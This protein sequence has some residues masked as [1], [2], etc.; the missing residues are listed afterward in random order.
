M[1]AYTLGLFSKVVFSLSLI[2]YVLYGLTY[3]IAALTLII[4]RNWLVIIVMAITIYL[5]FA[6]IYYLN[7]SLR[8]TGNLMLSSLVFA[9]IKTN[10]SLLYIGL[11]GLFIFQVIDFIFIVF[12]RDISVKN[13]AY[14]L[15]SSGNELAVFLVFLSYLSTRY[16]QRL[17]IVLSGY[18]AMV[19]FAI[20]A[21][22]L[23]FV[24]TLSVLRVALIVLVVFIALLLIVSGN[25]ELRYLMQNADIKWIDI[26]TGLRYSRL[27]ENINSVIYRLDNIRYF[28]MDLI[29][30][31]L[32]LG[33]FGIIACVLIYRNIY[34]ILKNRVPTWWIYIVFIYSLL[35]GH[36]VSS[37]SLGLMLIFLK[38]SFYEKS[39]KERI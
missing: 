35:F 2:S 25:P 16:I 31:Y 18:M 1:L 17:L 19:K 14:G 21:P 29:D 13:D 39:I 7:D 32:M 20:L 9:N 33:V 28:E 30:S 8:I 3:F 36:V 34:L 6:D 4:N 26:V 23:T 37:T 11:F 24:R 10:K 12:T 15:W 27:T 5:I 22:L 38:A